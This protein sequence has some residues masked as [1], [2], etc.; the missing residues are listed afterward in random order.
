MITQYL[1]AKQTAQID[2]IRGMD[3]NYYVKQFRKFYEGNNYRVLFC[4]PYTRQGIALAAIAPDG[5]T[6]AIIKIQ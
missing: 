4:E 2:H 5:E 3:I 6:L 1:N